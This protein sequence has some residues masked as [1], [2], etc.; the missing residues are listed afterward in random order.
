MAAQRRLGASLL[1]GHVTCKCCGELLDSD[2][3]FLAG[4]HV[5]DPSAVTEPSGLT[6]NNV[7]PACI[8]TNVAQPGVQAAL[9]VCVCA[10]PNLLRPW[11]MPLSIVT[12]MFCQP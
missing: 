12:E 2:R 10:V 9:Y 3:A 7:K 6:H 5:V 4:F 11:E 1:Q 8:L